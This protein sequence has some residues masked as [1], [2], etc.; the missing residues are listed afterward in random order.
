MRPGDQKVGDEKIEVY[1]GLSD[2]E[3]YSDGLDDYDDHD[4]SLPKA[5]FITRAERIDLKDTVIGIHVLIDVP[6]KTIVLIQTE[7][8]CQWLQWDKL[9]RCYFQ[10]HLFNIGAAS[11]IFVIDTNLFVLLAEKKLIV[12]ECFFSEEGRVRGVNVLNRF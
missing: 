11:K 4:A 8:H 6:D 2:P 5:V 1:E 12:Y 10:G 3:S 9:K 7:K